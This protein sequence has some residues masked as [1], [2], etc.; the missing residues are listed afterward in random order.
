MICCQQKTCRIYQYMSYSIKMQ[1]EM[2]QDKIAE[3]LQRVEFES[4][5]EISKLVDASVPTVRRDLNVLEATGRFQRTHGGPRITNPRSDQFT[6]TTR[7][8]HQLAEK[9][10]IGKT[11]A[12]LIQPNQTVI[13]DAGTTVFHVA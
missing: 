7:D 11:C 8:T 5:E 9:E 10:A 3:Y 6:F 4:L 1:P 2:R 13:M 12:E